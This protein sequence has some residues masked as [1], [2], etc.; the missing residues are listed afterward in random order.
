MV[1][2]IAVVD[3]VVLEEIVMLNVKFEAASNMKLEYSLSLQRIEK[4]EERKKLKRKRRKM[5]KISIAKK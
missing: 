3:A 1:A 2:V 5:R 4:F